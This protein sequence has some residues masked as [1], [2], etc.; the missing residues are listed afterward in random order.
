MTDIPADFEALLRPH[1]PFAGTEFLTADD[2]LSDL[3]LDSMALVAMMAD[4]ED[5]YH[6]ELPDEFLSEE[7]F[8]SVGS[9]WR[10]VLEVSR[11]YHPRSA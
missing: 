1:L 11:A 7:T 10:A 8:G 2:R 4:L 9:L 6:L 5:A 3:G